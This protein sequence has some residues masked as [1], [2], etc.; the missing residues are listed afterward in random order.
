MIGGNASIYRVVEG[1]R[2]TRKEKQTE[3]WEKKER[4]GADV[5]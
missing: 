3:E 4:G 1:Q 5:N 2:Y